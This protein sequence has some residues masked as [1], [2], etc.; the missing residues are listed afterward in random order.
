MT[1]RPGAPG[2]MYRV[3]DEDALLLDELPAGESPARER[4]GAFGFAPDGDDL[5]LA[6]DRGASSRR[7]RFSPIAVAAG[8]GA[9]A[10][11]AVETH[12]SVGPGLQASPNGAGPSAAKASR[13][14]RHRSRRDA[15][16]APA[17]RTGAGAR[18]RRLAGGAH[19]AAPRTPAPGP[20]PQAAPDVTAPV[21]SP[22]EFG[23]EQ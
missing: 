14:S 11:I 16:P 18:P 21:A 4:S 23:F 1:P 20:P 3:Y 15:R 12:A 5:P 13:R 19:R 6:P 17:L 8:L 7:R 22:H 10:A 2:E 9:I